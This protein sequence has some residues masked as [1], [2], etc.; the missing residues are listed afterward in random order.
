MCGLRQQQHTL[1]IPPFRNYSQLN[2]KMIKITIKDYQL[3]EITKKLISSGS[4][5]KYSWN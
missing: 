2:E 3:L 5:F 4:W 1:F